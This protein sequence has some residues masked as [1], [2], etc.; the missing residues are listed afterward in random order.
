MSSY[1]AQF[2]ADL[3]CPCIECQQPVVRPQHSREERKE[4]TNMRVTR[5]GVDSDDP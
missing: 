2:D 5:S 4:V 1:K 3:H